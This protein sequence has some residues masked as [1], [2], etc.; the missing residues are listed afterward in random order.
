M[1]FKVN[2][3]SCIKGNRYLFRDLSFSLNEGDILW[4]K[5]ANGSG[6]S[7]LLKILANLGSTEEGEI[8][9]NSEKAYL[10]H[11]DGIKRNLT[12][13]ENITLQCALAGQ[14]K[15]SEKRLSIFSDFQ[16]NSKAD[17]LC[18]TLSMGQRRKVALAALI[19]KQKPLWILDEPFTG[20]DESSIN[21][22]CG[23]L[24]EHALMGGIIIVASHH[25]DLTPTQ[26]I[27]LSSC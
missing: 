22:L 18:Q 5:G 27:E 14:N 6:K 16:L 11:K 10:G 24:R 21:V 26:S 12:A 25:F 13:I 23:Y 9:T 1:Y 17:S 19:L 4:V 8:E 2:R 7:S 20:L 3:L 15:K